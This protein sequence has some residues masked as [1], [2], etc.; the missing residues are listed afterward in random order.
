MECGEIGEMLR[1]LGLNPTEAEVK[2]IIADIDPTGEEVNPFLPNAPFLNPL[3]IS[4]GRKKVHWE[5]RLILSKV[6]CRE[7]TTLP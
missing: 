4:G 7:P 6:L 5:N 1:A 3:Q 2:K